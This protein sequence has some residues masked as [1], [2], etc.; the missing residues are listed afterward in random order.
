MQN[1]SVRTGRIV[2]SLEQKL[3]LSGQRVHPGGENLQAGIQAVC[4]TQCPLGTLCA[5]SINDISVEHLNGAGCWA[6]SP[7]SQVRSL[8]AGKGRQAVRLLFCPYTPQLSCWLLS[9]LQGSPGS[10]EHRQIKRIK[11]RWILTL[12]LRCD[13]HKNLETKRGS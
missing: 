5:L 9:H 1:S 7:C 13:L 3:V 6:V 4:G 10:R 12:Q 11:W 8:W 2:R